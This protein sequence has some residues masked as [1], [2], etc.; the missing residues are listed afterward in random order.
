MNIDKQLYFE[1]VPSLVSLIAFF[2]I[3]ILSVLL[4]EHCLDQ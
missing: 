4:V 3:L 2:C 1:R